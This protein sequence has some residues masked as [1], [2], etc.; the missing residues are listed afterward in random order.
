MRDTHL[1]RWKG[2]AE[3]EKAGKT[4]P[5]PPP[6]PNSLGGTAEQDGI[7][8]NFRLHVVNSLISI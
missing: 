1:C 2:N 8:P 6:P 5:Q 7:E 3:K 4:Y